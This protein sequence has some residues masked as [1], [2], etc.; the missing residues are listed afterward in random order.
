MMAAPFST[1]ALLLFIFGV[2]LLLCVLFSRA[3]ERLGLPVVLL[4]LLLGML[5]GSEGVGGIHFEDYQFAFRVGLLA[6]ILILFDG[7]LNTSFQSVRQSLFPAT[8][9]ATVG[10][11]ATAALVALLSHWLGLPWQAALLLGAVVSSTDAAT[12]FAVLRG[13]NLHLKSRVG[14]II[15]M[16]SGINDPMAVILT[17]VTTTILLGREFS[18]W[19]A[20]IGATLQLLIG[21]LV[22]LVLG[23]ALR[24]SLL[25]IRLTT[26]G[27]YPVLTLAVAILA[28]GS[29][30]LLQGSGFL[31]VFVTALVLGNGPLPYR[32]GLRRIHDAIAWLSQIA[33]FLMLGLLVFPSQLWDVVWVGLGVALLLA[34]VAR[35]LAVVL[36][37]APLRIPLT[38]VGYIGWVGLRGAVPIILA[39]FPILAGVS[40]ALLVF[41][42][43]FF[44]VVVNAF[45]PGITIRWLAQRLQLAEPAKPVPLAALEI[46]STRLLA[47]EVLSFHIS[48]ALAVCNATLAQ[49]PFPEGGAAI[50]V[51]RGDQLLAARGNTVLQPGDHVFVFCRPED[52]PF[53]ELLFGRPQNE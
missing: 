53:V 1:I 14:A 49:I 48:E 5:A 38:E 25:H 29:A 16:E 45:I 3:S 47:G 32:N 44:I 33:M 9:L 24:Y 13:S 31:A 12:V 27:L 43:V 26:V 6:L 50:L 4:F 22:G 7:G 17:L 51:V 30:T 28:F 52:K 18:V 20:V 15:E 40:E 39:T 36:C 21:L 37:L 34:L 2:L 10:V 41:N 8:L 11:L 23:Y 35:P 42:L 19:G 46:Q